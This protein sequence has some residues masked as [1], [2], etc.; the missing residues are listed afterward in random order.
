MDSKDKKR[1]QK[2]NPRMSMGNLTVEPT[3]EQRREAIKNAQSHSEYL[4]EILGRDGA[5]GKVDGIAQRGKTRG[6]KQES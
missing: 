3:K 6:K 4:A 2:T 1:K 5:N